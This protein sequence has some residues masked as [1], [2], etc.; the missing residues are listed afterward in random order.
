MPA[1]PEADTPTE[2]ASAGSFE[3]GLLLPE[4]RSTIRYEGSLTTPPCSETVQWLVVKKAI[5][6]SPEQLKAL[7]EHHQDNIRPP[8]ELNGR[9]VLS[10]KGPDA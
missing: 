1:K 5:T 8:Q 2:T 6:M 10:D 7:E 9:T 3:L 4:D